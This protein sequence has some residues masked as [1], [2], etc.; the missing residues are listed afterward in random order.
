MLERAFHEAVSST[1][2]SDKTLPVLTSKD[3]ERVATT[4]AEVLEGVVRMEGPGRYRVRVRS[5]TAA[6]RR[7]PHA[8]GACSVWKR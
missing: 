5:L 4:V 7:A 1:L 8:H 2:S 3:L 6:L